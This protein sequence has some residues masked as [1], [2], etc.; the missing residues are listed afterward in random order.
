VHD[1]KSLGKFM[2]KTLAENLIFVARA[3]DG[4]V[5]SACRGIDKEYFRYQRDDW[6]EAR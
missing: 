3:A 5:K 6:G 1:G 2:V 4:G